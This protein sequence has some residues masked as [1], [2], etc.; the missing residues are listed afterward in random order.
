MSPSMR[1][2]LPH[3]GTAWNRTSNRIGHVAAGNHI[4]SINPLRFIPACGLLIG[5]LLSCVARED[6]MTFDRLPGRA[7]K[8]R[9]NCRCLR[10][11]MCIG[12]FCGGPCEGIRGTCRSS[13]GRSLRGSHRRQS[14]RP[15][16]LRF[17]RRRNAR[18]SA[19]WHTL[20][21]QFGNGIR[22][23]F[24][25]P[26]R[27]WEETCLHSP[28]IPAIPAIP[29]GFEPHLLTTQSPF[30]RPS[31]EPFTGRENG[32]QDEQSPPQ[33]RFEEPPKAPAIV[34]LIPEVRFQLCSLVLL[35]RSA[36]QAGPASTSGG[37]TEVHRDANVLLIARTVRVNIGLNCKLIGSSRRR[38]VEPLNSG[39][40]GRIPVRHC[41]AEVRSRVIDLYRWNSPPEPHG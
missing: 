17:G 22:T 2:L 7:G 21:N 10:L 33:D 15:F 6:R 11:R 27:P 18:C 24:E 12:L 36:N 34:E 16:R 29:E 28:S 32:K 14:G 8:V 41:A 37:G 1:R 3:T 13:F 39:C 31:N 5:G 30:A 25:K 38:L 40:C 9:R 23:A 4:R 26:S 19:V 20:P 35:S